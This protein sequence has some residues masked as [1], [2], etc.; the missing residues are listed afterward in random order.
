MSATVTAVSSNGEYSFSKPNR[1]SVRLLAG[2]GVEG[3]C[4]RA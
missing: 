4:M 1:E 2:L 3:T